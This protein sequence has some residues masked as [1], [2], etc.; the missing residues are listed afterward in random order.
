[1]KPN[2]DGRS[3]TAYPKG[4]STQETVCLLT[5]TSN[6]G[7]NRTFS[8]VLQASELINVKVSEAE[9]TD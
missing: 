9:L 8:S 3:S 5:D 4:R 6:L 7:Q 2:T 1:M